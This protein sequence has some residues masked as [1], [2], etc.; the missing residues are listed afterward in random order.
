MKLGSDSC[1]INLMPGSDIRQQLSLFGSERFFR[2]QNSLFDGVLVSFADA[3]F[4]AALPKTD[5]IAID[6]KTL[7]SQRTPDCST[8]PFLF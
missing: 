1:R 4:I 5:S 3:P 8:K 2:Q 7:C 6:V